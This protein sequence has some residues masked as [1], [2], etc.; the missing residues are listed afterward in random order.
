MLVLDHDMFFGDLQL[1]R[2]L[3]GITLSHRIANSLPEE[4][5]THTHSDAHFVLITSGDYVSSARGDANRRTTLIYNP[6]GTTHRDHFWRGRG[7]F[8]TI[9]L[10][11]PRLAQCVDTALQAVAMYLRQD[12]ACGLGLA[13]LME[14]ARWNSSSKLQVESLCV[15]LLAE[16]SGSSPSSRRLP[17][18]WLRTACEL[19][20]DC[21]LETPGIRDVAKTVG[22]HPAHLARVFRTFLRCAPGDL[23]RARRLELAAAAL[24]K[25]DRSLAEIALDS[26][27]CDQAQFTKAFCRMYGVPPGAYRRL[28]TNA[29]RARNVAF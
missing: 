14:C 21:P 7:S 23:L 13:L 3:D 5:R 1:T 25:S 20:Q 2:A 4:V 24:M 6:P 9:S 10:S 26:G 28:S 18:Q 15:E 27:F 22:V 8:F 16:A 19:I 29:R 11:G 17:P 12:R